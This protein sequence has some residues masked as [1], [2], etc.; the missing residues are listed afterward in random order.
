MPAFGGRITEGEI[1]KIAAY[2]RSMSGLV[3][4]DAAPSRRDAIHVKEPENR[5]E[6]EQPKRASPPAPK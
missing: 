6:A 5:K 4:A 3:R 1:W 2:V